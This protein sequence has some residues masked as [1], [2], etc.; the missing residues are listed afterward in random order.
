MHHAHYAVAA[1][2]AAVVL[3]VLGAGG[4]DATCQ[5]GQ[6]AVAAATPEAAPV[7]LALAAIF[8]PVGD[9]GLE[10]TAETL[11]LRDQRVRLSG[12]MVHRCISGI[13]GQFMLTT[14]PVTLHEREMATA[15]DL[16][17][18]TVFVIL[19]ESEAGFETPFVP[20]PLELVGTL[21]LGPREEPGDRVSHVRLEVGAGWAA[22]LQEASVGQG[23]AHA[24][25]TPTP[26]ADHTPSR[27][28]P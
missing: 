21:R 15:D 27:H 23:H 2:A 24:A 12:F 16:P 3:F 11:A 4:A 18:G 9:L 25:Q 20:G 7:D 26:V 14:R 13:T 6:H 17:L 28:A 5:E 8:K 1:R 10:Y 19:S 22:R